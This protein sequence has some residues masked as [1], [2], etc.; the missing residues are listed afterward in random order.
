LFNK[1]QEN[2]YNKNTIVEYKAS[3]NADVRSSLNNENYYNVLSTNDYKETFKNDS[4]P[5]IVYNYY[6]PQELNQIHPQDSNLKFS[7]GLFKA[8]ESTDLNNSDINTG[9]NRIQVTKYY[10]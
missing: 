10:K 1:N 6:N 5:K 8:G 3:D 4:V 2:N 7:S 9:A